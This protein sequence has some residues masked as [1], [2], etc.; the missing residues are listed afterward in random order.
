MAAIGDV[1]RFTESVRQMFEL[2]DGLKALA[3]QVRERRKPLAVQVVALQ[4]EI[5]EFME[6]TQ[7]EVCNYN[8]HRLELH[9]VTRAGPMNKKSVHAALSVYF[10]DAEATERCMAALMGSLG[11]REVA[12]LKRFKSRKKPAAGA[13]RPRGARATGAG[14]AAPGGGDDGSDAAME[15][16]EEGSEEDDDDDAPPQL[17]DDSDEEEE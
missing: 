17:G 7:L 10:G 1:S 5:K 11:N 13:R 12:I 2:Q 4:D 15:E 3:T 14:G 9:R 16:Q 8:G 6:R